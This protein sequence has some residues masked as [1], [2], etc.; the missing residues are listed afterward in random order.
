MKP[1]PFPGDYDDLSTVATDSKKIQGSVLELKQQTI[2][3]S[4]AFHW[5][6]KLVRVEGELDRDRGPRE[7]DGV[8]LLI[9]G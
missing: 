2:Y 6:E 1:L 3:N 5:Y 4:G 7:F 8:G 9:R